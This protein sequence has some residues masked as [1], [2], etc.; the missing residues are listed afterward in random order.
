MRID[1]FTTGPG[2]T[3]CNTIRPVLESEAAAQGLE[4]REIDVHYE[5]A[6]EPDYVFRTPVVHVN[7]VRIAEGR[8]DPDRLRGRIR[9]LFQKA[10]PSAGQGGREG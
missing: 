8:I 3:L 6:P 10:E 4:L 2:C 5:S 7:G 9:A 1:F